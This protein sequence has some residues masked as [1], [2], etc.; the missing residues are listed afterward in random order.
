MRNKMIGLISTHYLKFDNYFI[1]DVNYCVYFI[2]DGYGV[3]IGV[4]AS[5]PTRIKQLQT[6]NPR[7][8]QAMYI[9]KAKNQTQAMSIE[10]E[11]HKEFDEKH[12]IGEW[13]DI[14][15]KEIEDKCLKLGYEIGKPVS[16]FDFG[17]DGVT[18]I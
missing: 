11:L 13:Y 16:K 1:E 9:I 17:V 2:T 5:L 4:A 15:D 18:A 8:L 7:R 6:G 10:G 12:L 14:T 3:K